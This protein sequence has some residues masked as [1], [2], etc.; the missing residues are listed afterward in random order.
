MTRRD[1]VKPAFS[2]RKKRSVKTHAR[3]W[4]LK[5]FTSLTLRFQDFLRR[6]N[7]IRVDKNALAVQ[8]LK[9]VPSIFNKLER[10]LSMSLSRM[11]DIGG[12]RA[13]VSTS[14]L[15][16]RIYKILK[17]SRTKHIL[18]RERHY[19]TNPKESGYRG[20][21][22]IYKYNG[23]KDKFKGLPVEIQIRSKIQHSW[24]TAV[25]VVGTFTKQALKAHT[26]DAD[27]LFRKIRGKLIRGGTS[28]YVPY[29]PPSATAVC[30]L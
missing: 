29:F 23:S 11:E 13:V 24:A 12:C 15:V 9:Q 4:G 14:T 28:W 19:I 17:N 6:K 27:W 7:A 20:I 10:E 1:F 30:V 3:F 21:H 25:E 8:R 22:L 5:I 26:G 16:N 2:L 18:H